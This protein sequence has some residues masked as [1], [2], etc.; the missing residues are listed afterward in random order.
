[1][2]DQAHDF[3]HPP[4]GCSLY[5]AFTRRL[6]RVKTRGRLCVLVDETLNYAH[7]TCA[8]I[9]E[10]Q[11]RSCS[12]S[13]RAGARIIPGDSVSVYNGYST[14]RHFWF[15]WAECPPTILF[16]PTAEEQK[17]KTLNRVKPV[18]CPTRGEQVDF[19]LQLTNPGF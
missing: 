17:P 19:T 1:M 8:L 10:K 12:C 16:R 4:P 13:R 2:H 7:L 3:R 11:Q 6:N 15:A 9:L 5:Q 14:I 18:A